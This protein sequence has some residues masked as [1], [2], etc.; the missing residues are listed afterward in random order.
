M[1]VKVAFLGDQQSR[2]SADR[3]AGTPKALIPNSAVT[4]QDG[5]PSI[6]LVHDGKVERRAVTLGPQRGDDV[7]VLAGVS[8]GDTL[9]AKVPENLRD[10]QTVDVKK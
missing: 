10:G 7:E 3:G 1:G 5:K 9:V 6:F 2:A 4:H 8:E